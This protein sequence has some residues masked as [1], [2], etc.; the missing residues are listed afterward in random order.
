MLHWTGGVTPE[1][2]GRLLAAAAATGDVRAMPAAGTMRGMPAAGVAVRAGKAGA[3]GT[4]S[5]GTG[6]MTRGIAAGTVVRSDGR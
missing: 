3:E 2:G 6:V 1:L 4:G 5:R